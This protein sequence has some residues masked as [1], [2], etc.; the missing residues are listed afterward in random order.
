[1]NRAALTRLPLAA[2]MLLVTAL[3][4]PVV[5][6][7]AA[8]ATATAHELTIYAA[9]STVQFM[10]HAD[11]RLRGMAISPFNL[12]A[13]AVI[14]IANGKEA[15]NGPFPGDDI[16]YGFKLYAAPKPSKPIGSATFTCYYGFG[17]QATCDSYFNL[18]EGLILASGQITFAHPHFTLAVTGG[19]RTYFGALGQIVSAPAAG[20][21][22]RF[23]LQ[24]T[25]QKK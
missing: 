20:N 25:G 8:Q 15:A 17:K 3:V 4:T 18:A 12:K 14:V 9:P 23:D 22:Q 13:E 19:T 2:M 11:E 16:L 21:V 1:V 10:N 5:A 7:A 6:A 24:L